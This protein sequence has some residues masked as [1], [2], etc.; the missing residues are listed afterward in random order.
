MSGQRSA[1][2][3]SEGLPPEPCGSRPQYRTGYSFSCGWRQSKVADVNTTSIGD[4]ITL[5]CRT[6]SGVFNADDDD[7]PF[8]ASSVRPDAGFGFHPFHSES[9]VPGRHLN[10]L[11]S[12]EDAL[13]ISIDPEVI[14]SSGL[15]STFPI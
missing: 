15:P 8:F 2:V 5:G 12:A 14:L 10:A 3:E 4:G 1:R 13:Q 11:L 7:V 6:M 9:H